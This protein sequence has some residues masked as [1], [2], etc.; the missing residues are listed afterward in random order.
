MVLGLAS[1]LAGAIANLVDRLDDGVVTDYLHSGWWP[2]FNLADVFITI[3]AV[4]VLTSLFARRHERST[5]V[6]RVASSE[7]PSLRTSPVP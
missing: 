7:R 4:A 3:G 2:T 1:V 6:R 5:T